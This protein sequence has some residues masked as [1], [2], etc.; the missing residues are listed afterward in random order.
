[1]DGYYP[2]TLAPKQLQSFVRG[3][4]LALVGYIYS[5]QEK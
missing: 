2:Q 1:M 3:R 4:I 5:L